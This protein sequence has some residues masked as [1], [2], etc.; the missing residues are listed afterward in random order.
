MIVLVVAPALTE[1]WV[2]VVGF[3]V[4]ISGKLLVL[5]EGIVLF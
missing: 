5:K 3:P 4:C 2:C 1:A